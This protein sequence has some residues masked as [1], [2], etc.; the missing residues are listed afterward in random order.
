MQ[1]SDHVAMFLFRLPFLILKRRVESVYVV[2]W[3]DVQTGY[4]WAGVPL[5]LYFSGTNSGF[6]VQYLG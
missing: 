2:F 1:P 5:S 6:C 4:V 3:V